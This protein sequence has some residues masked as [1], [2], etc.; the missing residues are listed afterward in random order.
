MA[1][2][3]NDP[4][5]LSADAINRANAVFNATYDTVNKKSNDPRLANDHAARAVADHLK[6][7][8]IFKTVADAGFTLASQMLAQFFSLI[9]EFRHEV[10]HTF[11][12]TTA[13]VVNEFLGTNLDA[14]VMKT[15]TGGD[16]T[17]QKANAI[18][19]AVLN[20]LEQ[21]FAP[22]GSVSPD[23]GAAAARTFAGYGVNFAIQNALISLIGAC[24]PETRLDDLRELGVE[25]AGNL[26]LGALVS[27]AIAPLVDNTI[28]RPYTRQLKAKY[29]QDLIGYAELMRAILR[30]T[31][32][33]DRFMGYIREQGFSDDQITEVISQMQPRL[34]SSEWNVLVALGIAPSDQSQLE[35]V[36]RGM[37]AD[38]VALKQRAESFHRLQRPRQRALQ[39][40]MQQ[41][42]N[43]FLDLTALEKLFTELQIPDDEAAIWRL[44]AGYLYEHTR[45][46]LSQSDMLFLY[47]AA[48]ITDQD[49]QDWAIANGYSTDDAL[50]MVTIFQ[51]RA[52][53]AASKSTGGAAARAAHL[54]NE[55]VAF[56]T[57]E[58]T[59]LFGRAPTTAELNYWV[60]LLDTGERTKHDF[61]TE[62]KNLPSTGSAI[63]PA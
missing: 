40:V 49:V 62:L 52:S 12:D 58:I 63:P 18:G 25:V 51:L 11:D 53:E 57:D 24:I 43:G 36:G 21:E 9:S 55:H 45:K 54:H 46:R 28:V 56:V 30:G 13:E 31:V 61:T 50:T 17:I 32:D 20:R 14:S 8:G 41:I 33:K 29:Q 34:R 5:Q 38:L 3:P 19:G 1:S 23:T 4:S 7:G 42:S 44:T 39:A 2:N 59:G 35:D 10:T 48:Q 26:G 47:E 60:K 6:A 16:E 22:N 15:G 37:P 27:S